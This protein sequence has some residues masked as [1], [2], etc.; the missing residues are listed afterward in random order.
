MFGFSRDAVTLT[1]TL[2]EEFGL[3]RCEMPS[4]QHHYTNEKALRETQ[5]LRAHRSPPIDA[6]SQ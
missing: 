2:Q 1:I 6:Q 3:S 5:T 4:N